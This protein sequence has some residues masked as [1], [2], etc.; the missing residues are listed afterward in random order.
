MATPRLFRVVKDD[1]QRVTR[2]AMH[3]ADPVA[4]IDAVVAARA[5][6]WPV[7]RRENNRLALI[8][9]HYFGFGLRARLLLDQDEFAAIPVSPALAQQEHHL[10]REGDLA[11]KIL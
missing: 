9:S 3:A 6:H 10:Q 1:A 8:R 2:A 4:Q 11:V 5:F 7:P